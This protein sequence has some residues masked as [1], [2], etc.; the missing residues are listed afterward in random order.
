M[1]TD[2]NAES[3]DYPRIKA[4]VRGQVHAALGHEARG[5]D[6][7]EREFGE[8]DYVKVRDKQMRDLALED[9]LLSKAP[10]RCALMRSGKPRADDGHE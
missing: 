6:E 7:V 8:M 9:D 1:W 2:S 5:W 4:L 10:I 3:A